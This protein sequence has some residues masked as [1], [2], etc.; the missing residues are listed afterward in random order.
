MKTRKEIVDEWA[1]CSKERNEIAEQMHLIEPS[2]RYFADLDAYKILEQKYNNLSA[3][4]LGLE[5]T[6]S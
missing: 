6:L 3:R 2:S 4:M 5:F 1:R